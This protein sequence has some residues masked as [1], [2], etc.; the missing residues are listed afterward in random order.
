[1]DENSLK[2]ARWRFYWKIRFRY[3]EFSEEKCGIHY[4]VW[5]DN[6]HKKLNNE[7]ETLDKDDVNY[8]LNSS[9]KFLENVEKIQMWYKKKKKV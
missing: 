4:Y 2:L 1:M 8:Y 6:L 5:R 3:D 7:W 9:E